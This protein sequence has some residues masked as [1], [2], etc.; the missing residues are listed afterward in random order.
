MSPRAR[1]LTLTAHVVLSVGWL[2][3]V[4][5]YLVVAVMALTGRDAWTMRAAYFSLDLIGWRVIVPC[6]VLAL[7][8]GL[9][10]SL[11]TEWGLV[12]HRW[13]VAKLALTV[14]AVVVLLVHMPTVSRVSIAASQTTA[15]DGLRVLGTQLVV[16]AAGGLVVLLTATA[17]S[18]FKP[19]G[20]TR[21][22]RAASSR[23]GAA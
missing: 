10:Q 5:A 8:V 13:V 19:W 2:G 6:S 21:W 11:G 17:L 1:K 7:L 14:G 16:H 20:K 9:V 23:R 4:A 3:A 22:G 15:P 18:V 12:R